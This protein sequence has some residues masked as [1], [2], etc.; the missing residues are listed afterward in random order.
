MNWTKKVGRKQVGRKLGARCVSIWEKI[1]IANLL[2]RMEV[3]RVH[4]MDVRG[5]CEGKNKSHQ[6]SLSYEDSEGPPYG[7]R[8][9]L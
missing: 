8:G 6:P 9:F 7:C 2:F 5:F 3:L 1:K 4:P